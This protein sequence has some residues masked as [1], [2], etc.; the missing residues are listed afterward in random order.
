[1]N[2]VLLIFACAFLF[3]QVVVLM[4]CFDEVAVVVAVLHGRLINV[5]SGLCF[6]VRLSDIAVVSGFR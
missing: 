3:V 2:L 1:M 5:G 6:L 4:L